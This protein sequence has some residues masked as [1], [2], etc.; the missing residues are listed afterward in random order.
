MYYLESVGLQPRTHSKYLSKP[1]KY[2]NDLKICDFK[3][4]VK[5]TLILIKRCYSNVLRS[6]VCKHLF[7]IYFCNS[8]GVRLSNTKKIQN[9][10]V[11]Q[12]TSTS[13]VQ[14]CTHTRTSMPRVSYSYII[15]Y[16]W[17]L[18]CTILTKISKQKK[19]TKM[20]Y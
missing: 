10:V 13:T 11:L 19:I 4:L 9:R 8:V 6:N 18:Y 3:D 12:F 1:S 20:I 5:S 17:A 14:C 15:M 16:C 2:H 7:T